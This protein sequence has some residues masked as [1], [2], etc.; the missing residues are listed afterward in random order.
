MQESMQNG[1]PVVG[2]TNGAIYK[3]WEGVEVK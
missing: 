1:V 3:G 2:R